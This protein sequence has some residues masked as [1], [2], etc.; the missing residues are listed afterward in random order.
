MLNTS[1]ILHRHRRIMLNIHISFL[2]W[3]TEVSGFFLLFFGVYV[4]GHEN[5]LVTYLMQ[6]LTLIVYFN[7]LPSV[8]LM[9]TPE[10][11]DLVSDSQ[12]YERFLNLFNWQYREEPE[13]DEEE[14]EGSEDNQEGDRDDNQQEI[15]DNNEIVDLENQST[16]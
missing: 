15:I 8:L 10:F 3:M 5:N 7:L 16:D 11:K 13:N 6:T 14:E 1:S 4:V 2:A 12:V 9:N